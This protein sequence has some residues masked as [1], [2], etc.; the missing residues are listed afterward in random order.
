MKPAAESHDGAHRAGA[1]GDGDV[2]VV[3]LGAGINGA[4]LFRDLCAQGVSCCIVDKAD[5]LSLSG[6]SCPWGHDPA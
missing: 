3:I 6:R 4:G 2:D 5:T 1:P